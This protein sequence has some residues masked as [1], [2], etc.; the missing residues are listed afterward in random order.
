M[1]R[2][3]RPE[4][5]RARWEPVLL[6]PSGAHCRGH[7]GHPR[8]SAIGAVF[9]LAAVFCLLVLIAAAAQ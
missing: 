1:A 7:H 9:A 4:E 5:P 2:D 8:W 6:S 3:S